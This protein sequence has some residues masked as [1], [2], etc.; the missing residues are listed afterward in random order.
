LKTRAQ[1]CIMIVGP[2]RSL[3]LEGGDM[4]HLSLSFLGSFQA[5][6]DG[7][8]ITRFESN[9]V[10]AL[11]AYLAV[12]S[13]RAHSRETLAALFWPDWPPSAALS[14]LRFAL[15]NLR[16]A[17]GD[18]TANPPYLLI[19]RETIQFNQA[20]QARL[21]VAEF[22]SQAPVQTEV[23]ADLEKLLQAAELY[24]GSFL[25]GLSLVD[26]AEFEEWALVQREEFQR[27]FLLTLHTIAAFYE[28]RGELDQAI[29]FAR[30]QVN[31]EPEQEQAHQQLMRLLALIGRRSAALMQYESC[32]RVLKEKLGVEPAPETRALFASIGDGSFVKTRP[33][34]EGP[35]PPAP[36]EPPFKGLQYFEEADA[37]LFFGREKLVA[38]LVDRLANEDRQT[39]R[40]DGQGIFLAVIGA[41]GSG[42][43]SLVR[44]GLIP[45]LKGSRPLP[46]GILTPESS[47]AWLFHTIT[48]TAHPLEALAVSL[49]RTSESVFATATLIDDLRREPRSLSLYLQ[50]LMRHSPSPQPPAGRRMCLFID[51]FEEIFTL[52]RDESERRAFIDNLMAALAA[53][54]VLILALRADIYAAC[55]PYEQL[56]SALGEHQDYIGPMNGLELRLAIEEPARRGG[57]TLEAGLVDLFLNDIGAA[58]NYLPEP[59]ALPLLSHA[60]LE[61]W[62]RRRG[63]TLTLAGYAEAGGVKGAI[64]KTA[65]RVFAQLNEQEQLIA[66]NIFLKLTELGDEEGAEGYSAPETRRRAGLD[67]LLPASK[68]G[69]GQGLAF[70]N[71]L[72]LLV[73]ARLVTTDQGSAEVAHEA[74]IREWTRLREWLTDNRDALRLQRSISA[75]AL[76]WN[77]LHRDL[78]ALLRGSR[79]A[80]ALEW[81]GQAEHAGELSALEQNFVATSQEY[82][83]C[84]NAER[85]AQRQREL[86][87]ARQLAE[88]EKQRSAEQARAGQQLRRRAYFLAAVLGATLVILVAAI[89]FWRSANAQTTLAYEQAELANQQTVLANQ[90]TALS[91]GREL[92]LA[93]IN[94][95]QE[96]PERSIL[97][98]LEAVKKDISAELAVPP[99]TQNAL[100]RAVLA[101]RIRSRLVGHTGPINAVAYSQDGKW[102]ATASDDQKAIIW[103]ATTGARLFTLPHENAVGNVAFSPDGISLATADVVGNVAFWDV[104]KGVR[105]AN[106]HTID[107]SIKGFAFSPDGSMLVG[108]ASDGT[109]HAFIIHVTSAQVVQEY[110]GVTSLIFSPAGKQIAASTNDGI[111][112]WDWNMPMPPERWEWN[113]LIPGMQTLD[114]PQNYNLIYSPDGS[115]LAIPTDRGALVLDVA[116]GK[117]LFVLVGHL[118]GHNVITGLTGG[119]MG[120]AFNPDGRYLATGAMDGKAIVWDLTN[121]LPFISLNSSAGPVSSVVFSPECAQLPKIPFCGAHLVT[122]H[123]NGEAIIWDVS[124]AGTSEIASLP[125][126]QTFF[127][128][129]EGQL[130]TL[131]A[132]ADF[133]YSLLRWDLQ[134]DSQG[135]PRVRT[136]GTWQQ[137]R[138]MGNNTFDRRQVLM[139]TGGNTIRVLDVVSGEEKYVWDAN[140]HIGLIGWPDI[141][142]D[143]KLVSLTWPDGSVTLADAATG[144]ELKTIKGGQPFRVGGQFFGFVGAYL[145]RDGT[146]LAST[147]TDGTV[148]VWNVAS[149]KLLHSLSDNSKDVITSAFSGDGKRIIT[150]SGLTLVQWDLVSEKKLLS[151][152]SGHKGSVM[153][154]DFSQDG[155]L[156]V[157]GGED[158]MA[159]LRDADNGQEYLTLVGHNGVVGSV[160]FSPDGRYLACGDTENI[161]QVYMLQID[162]LVQLARSRLTRALTDSECLNYLHV[163]H[164][165]AAP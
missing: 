45:A 134:P 146:L 138:F 32:R 91:T 62:K 122:A 150:T 124:P 21:D 120:I 44:A 41:S 95:L 64:A 66:R 15:S 56:R 8:P 5:T 71:V 54:L 75:A 101:S 92:S 99:E 81:L 102:I 67:E 2:N 59:G 133:S 149:G 162:D 93:A 1:L 29:S 148:K 39:R 27:C 139:V 40:D 107:R 37:G 65:E 34:T 127:T 42:K 28:Q 161:V 47:P 12:E 105:L 153:V 147:S 96:D 51:Q 94:N 36:G 118:A 11:L 108:V 57:W 43:S 123:R 53:P 132:N 82:A 145:S 119:V 140:T 164:C 89:Y 72:Q 112:I 24:R 77:R 16:E 79:L 104:I 68:A 9:R 154:I 60:L 160:S 3:S 35:E 6:L 115:R 103:D 49:T 126:G 74:L 129:D 87:A 136:I 7:A 30:R 128:S 70:E 125:G 142:A 158:G 90:Q 46:N 80:R 151:T 20:S 98:A 61:T 23:D 116:T 78:G 143:G 144:Q 157:T 163:P 85:E 97:L 33:A 17:I 83:E 106:L 63:R 84:E 4:A 26:S 110:F 48:P 117:K 38:Q 152:P 155:K 165:P 156:M 130:V 55:A 52:C 137:V 121:G 109:E 111:K 141:S 113:M 18:R 135:G 50:K 88:A 22:S 131:V 13:Q 69:P 31:A 76:E 58:G 159:I 114:A 86:V 25:E 73:D 10:R 100:H 14:N 19:N